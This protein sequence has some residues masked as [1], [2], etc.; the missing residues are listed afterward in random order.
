METTN[1]PV[2]VKDMEY[3][4][5]DIDAACAEFVSATEHVKRASSGRELA[6]IRNEIIALTK[7]IRTMNS[8]CHIRFTLNTRDEYYLAEK[9]YYDEN[10][11]KLAATAVGFNKAFL[12]SPH[13]S[14]A[15]ELMNPN[16]AKAYELAIKV[17]DEKIVADMAEEAALV[18]E[19]DRLMSE[20]DF[21]FRGKRMPLSMLRKYF[22]DADRDVRR[23]ATETAGRRMERD[24]D[25]LDGLFDKLVKVRAR[26]AKKMGLPSYAVMG[27]MLM[28]R[29]SYGRKEI[30]AFREETARGVTPLVAEMKRGFARELGIDR[31][32]LYDNEA[33]F[34]SG[35]PAPAHEPEGLFAAAKAMYHD[36]SREA[37]EFIDEMLAADA[38]D[39]FARDGKWGGGYCTSIDDYGQ[40]FILANFN[41]SSG[42]V[43]VLTHE[44]GHAL[45]YY[46]MFRSGADYELE[47]GT[48]SVAEIHSMA[49][50]FFA[51]KY[52][53]GF[54]GRRAEDYKRMHLASSLTF[55]PYGAEVDEF[56]QTCYENAD[57]TPAER[58]ALWRDLDAKYRPYLSCEGLPY[59]ERGTRWQ[60]QMHIYENPMYYIDYCLSQTVAHRFL[61]L[62][63]R[64][65]DDA[66]ARYMRL[67]RVAGG[68]PF[69][70]LVESV[71]I[72][73]PL[74]GSALTATTKEVIALLR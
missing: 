14:D 23:K 39:V 24:A 12:A 9:T 50:E 15:L 25:R 59:F 70:E 34:K 48:M 19:Y 46:E 6:D 52:A 45:A 21:R 63:R 65:Y 42:D 28:G 10:L 62:S 40:P 11:P 72:A 3:R 13:L 16:I 51:W 41:G 27:D 68:M 36:M 74:K 1:G 32:M 8:L 7:H 56:Q 4:R 2:K 55:L 64:D 49:M 35:N 20:M 38:F 67:L 22:D 66:F 37:G 54:F 30:E 57:M 29:Y 53:E 60:Y 47:L 18:T 26:M 17:T 58:N 33:Y 71:G 5:A 69:G 73:D 44:A 61:L 31:I 43:D